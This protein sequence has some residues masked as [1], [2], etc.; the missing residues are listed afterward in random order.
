[1]ACFSWGPERL[2][3]LVAGPV[4]QNALEHGLGKVFAGFAVVGEAG[5]VIEQRPVVAFEQR[6]ELVEVVGPDGG[7][8]YF[9]ARGF[10][11]KCLGVGMKGVPGS[12]PIVTASPKKY[13]PN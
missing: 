8:Q 11:G 4:L 5:E 13:R 2:R 1:M 3:G 10:H 7:H 12:G 9:V 6:H